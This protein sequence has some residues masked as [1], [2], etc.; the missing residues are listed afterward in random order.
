LARA[1]GPPIIREHKES[2]SMSIFD[3]FASA[4]APTVTPEERAEARRRAEAMA[5]VPDDWLSLALDHH[6]QIERLFAQARNAGDA[7]SRRS[8]SRQLDMILTGHA[9]AEESV[10]Y[11]MLAEDH[12][13][14]A[15]HAYQEQ[16]MTK[17]EMHKLEMLEPM[18]QEWL[19]K[20]DHIESAVQQHIYEEENQWFG[21]VRETL[22]GGDSAMHSQ[23]FR[24]EF[25]RYTGGGQG[26]RPMQIA[27]QMGEG[28]QMHRPSGQTN[29]SQSSGED[30]YG[31]TAG[32]GGLS[33]SGATDEIG[34]HADERERPGSF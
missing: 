33:E 34:D 8:A 22:Q 9:N 24:E 30:A 11:P 19:D 27:A 32:A 7:A 23:R 5:R 2:Q 3:K 18:S 26:E 1:P 16:A 6:R 17:V 13:A 10:I 28:G 21:E 4:V 15:A 14:H 12:K 31:R 20:L 25:E 29:F